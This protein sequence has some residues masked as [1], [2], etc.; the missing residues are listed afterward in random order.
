MTEPLRLILADYHDLTRWRWR[1]Q[2]M[3]RASQALAPGS[4]KRGVLFYGV[5]GAGKTACAL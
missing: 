4:A 3:L 5:P 2:P 1:L